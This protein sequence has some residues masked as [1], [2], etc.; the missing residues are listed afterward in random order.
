MRHDIHCIMSYR[1]S[2]R[3]VR[4]NHVENTSAMSSNH[5]RRTSPIERWNRRLSGP[6]AQE[7]SLELSCH[8]RW[9]VDV[10]C[11]FG[12]KSFR[13]FSTIQLCSCYIWQ[14]YTSLFHAF[15]VGCADANVNPSVR[16]VFVR[17]STFVSFQWSSVGS[18]HKARTKRHH[19]SLWTRQS[20]PTIDTSYIYIYIIRNLISCM[21]V[22]LLVVVQRNIYIYV[23]IPRK[24]L[25]PDECMYDI[26]LASSA[27]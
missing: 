8:R 22:W 20:M 18:I 6:G 11:S 10:D 27:T 9:L 26:G 24:H 15:Y 19:N 13:H 25:Q 17:W 7:L 21:T 16:W 3:M 23:E 14:N 12:R 4:F 1:G 2:N 5:C